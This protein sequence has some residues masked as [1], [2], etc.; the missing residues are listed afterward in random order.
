MA[1]NFYISGILLNGSLIT[2]LLLIIDFYLS[3][4]LEKKKNVSKIYFL[5]KLFLLLLS[6]YSLYVSSTFLNDDHF[7]WKSDFKEEV[8]AYN[9][10]CIS[11]FD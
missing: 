3:K 6:G 2:I 11:Y 9:A 1:E 5:L 4:L 7:E 10:D 8:K